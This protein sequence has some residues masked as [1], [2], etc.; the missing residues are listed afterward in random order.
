MYDTNKN[1]QLIFNQLSTLCSST[2]TT[3]GSAGYSLRTATHIP[4]VVAKCKSRQERFEP[5]NNTER[6]VDWTSW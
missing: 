1:I 5:T 3:F 6:S 2:A 4:Q